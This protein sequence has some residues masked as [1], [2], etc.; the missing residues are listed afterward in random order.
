MNVFICFSLLF[1]IITGITNKFGDKKYLYA[2]ADV[3]PN[4]FLPYLV[5]KEGTIKFDSV[6]GK[7]WKLGGRDS[8]FFYKKSGSYFSAYPIFTAVAS[9]PIYLS[10]YGFFPW[11]GISDHDDVKKI[12]FI[13]RLASGFFVAGSIAFFYLLISKFSKEKKYLIPFIIFY[14][15]GTTTFS[16]SSL[17]LWQHTVAQ[18]I[19]TGIVILLLKISNRETNRNEDIKLGLLFGFL[20]LTRT[21]DIVFLPFFYLIIIL[22]SKKSFLLVTKYLLPFIV[23]ILCYNWYFYGSPF[24]EGYGARGDL[25]WTSDLKES[26]PGLLFK[27]PARSLLFISP[28]LL[29]CFFGVFTFTKLKVYSAV[30]FFSFLTFLMVNGKWYTWHG[31]TGFGYR[32]LT[33]SL[34]ILG[35]FAFGF[36]RKLKALPYYLVILAMIYSVIVNSIG[37]FWHKGR[38]P[39]VHN[40]DYYCLMPIREIK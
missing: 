18:L 20:M 27:S 28:P 16:I 4:T 32:M 26:I 10:F 2:S 40:Y 22:K 21:V 19:I 25:H 38:C 24:M 9:V 7:L 3:L 35:L 29:L 5:I 14:A 23:F 17:S 8:Y 12:L 36:F 6:E 15:F 39:S 34:P 33:E 30:L 1:S 13:G 31:G 11:G 37:V